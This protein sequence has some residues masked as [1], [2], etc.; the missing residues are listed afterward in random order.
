MRGRLRARGVEG[1]LSLDR[2]VQGTRGKAV[3]RGVALMVHNLHAA[4]LTLEEIR[5]EMHVALHGL[6]DTT[7]DAI[8]KPAA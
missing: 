5:D 7:L 8:T 4:G 1:S 6:V 2:V 3:P